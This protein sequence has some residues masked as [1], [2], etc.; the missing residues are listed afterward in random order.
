MVVVALVSI[1]WTIWLI[2]LTIAPNE[3]ANAIMSTGGYDDGQF[4][5][6]SKKLTALQVFSVVGLVVVAIIIRHLIWKLYMHLK[7]LTGFHGKYRKLWNLCLKVLDLVMQ[8]FVLH[9]MLEE[10]IPVNL[11][12]AFAGFI[13]LNSISTAIAILGGKHT[14]LAEVLIDS[15][16][17]LGATVLLPIVLLAY[18]SYTFD[19]DHDTFHIYMELMPVGSFERRARMFG[20]PTEIELFRVSFGSLRIRSVPDLL[21]RIGMNLGFSYRF[22]RVVEVLIQIQT[23]HVKSYQKSVPRSISLFFATFGVGILVVTYQAITMSQAICKP[24]PEC[25]VYAYRLKHSEFCPCKALVNGNRAP[26][27]YYEWTHPV[28]ATDMVKALAAAGTLETLQ[29]INRQLTVFPDELRGCHNLK[30]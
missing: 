21:L 18:C 6:I 26:K 11:T 2:L 5:L 12:V 17:D 24:H 27:T 3:T 19:Y 23:E 4:W 30:Y 16:F 25:V 8:T 13:A 9:K 7:E 28:D 1:F 14:A 10:G 20:N 22:K 15:L 29:L